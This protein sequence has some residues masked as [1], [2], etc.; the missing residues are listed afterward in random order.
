MYIRCKG[1]GA[2][3]M[4][5]KVFGRAYTVFYANIA[6]HLDTFF[7]EHEFCNEEGNFMRRDDFELVY[8]S[9]TD[10]MPESDSNKY[11]ELYPDKEIR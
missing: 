5:G 10:N 8:E 9:T 7:K 2:V 4:I 1:C 6:D 3:Y 11:P